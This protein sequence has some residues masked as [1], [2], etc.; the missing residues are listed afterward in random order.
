MSSAATSVCANHRSTPAPD[1]AMKWEIEWLRRSGFNMLRKHIKVE[2]ARYYY[3]CDRLG[4][5]V[6]Q[7]MPAGF[8]Q[9]LRNSRSDAGEPVRLSTSRE[10]HELELR[11]M[12]GRLYNAPS[13]IVWV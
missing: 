2:P 8:N 5:L 7:D 11:R 9:G 1:A 6:W 13:I 12:I 4:M 10:Q 3:H